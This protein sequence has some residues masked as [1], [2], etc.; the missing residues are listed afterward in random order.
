MIGNLKEN[1][2]KNYFTFLDSSH[3]V[4]LSML[5]KSLFAANQC[6]KF[7]RNR[8]VVNPVW[9]WNAS[10]YLWRDNEL[11][12]PYKA[13]RVLARS[14]CHAI[15]VVFRNITWQLTWLFRWKISGNTT[16]C[17]E[18]CFYFIGYLYSWTSLILIIRFEIIQYFYDN[19][20]NRWSNRF[21]R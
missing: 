17:S 2:K 5:F 7:Q 3:S 16:A 4:S 20:S 8:L 13:K 19:Q 14:A 10:L 12:A 21:A 11:G 1:R 15:L 6:S 9:F 18:I